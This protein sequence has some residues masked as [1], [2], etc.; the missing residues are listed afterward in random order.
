MK[1]FFS[2]IKEKFSSEP[3]EKKIEWSEAV[4]IYRE[5][6]SEEI[7]STEEEAEELVEKTGELM[8][9]LDSD[10]EEISGYTDEEDLNVVEDVAENFYTSR[11]NLVKNFE[12]S[13][14]IENHYG[15]LNEF[16]EEF[17]DVSM[18]EGAVMKRVEK[19]SGQLS[20][21]LQELMEHRDRIGE[22][23]SED[24][25]EVKK[26]GEIQEIAGEIKDI[27]EKIQELSQKLEETGTEDLEDQIRGIEQEIEDFHESEEW[28][29]KKS[30][31]N[32]LELL[33]EKKS[34][35]KKNLSRKVSSIERGLKKLVYQVENQGKSFEGDL[36]TLKQLLDE[37]FHELEDPMPE[38]RESS[39]VL[40]EEEILDER[41]L[42]KFRNG[43]KEFENISSDLEEIE[44][45]S[46]NIE[47]VENKLKEINLEDKE[48]QLEKRRRS[49]KERIKEKKSQIADIESRK[50]DREWELEEKKKNLEKKMDEYL[51]PDISID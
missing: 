22:F 37:N 38:L 20:G 7:T 3:E 28:Q 46:E 45:F 1:Q 43:V 4:D 44:E 42:E 48:N 24:Y 10:L 50:E 13:E 39:K 2:K 41:Q 51:K 11:K 33:E 30:L 9:R 18:K 5:R 21:T 14:G 16:V 8:D 23:L 34:Q 35:R 27:Q 40:E 49:L 12:P 6:K 26:L 17:N 25:D 19:S 36:E 32:E 15:D 29:N 47:K 31:E